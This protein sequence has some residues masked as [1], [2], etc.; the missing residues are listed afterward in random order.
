MDVNQLGVAGH[1]VR[2]ADELIW[3][4]AAIFAAAAWQEN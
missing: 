4:C 2:L 3:H 1:S